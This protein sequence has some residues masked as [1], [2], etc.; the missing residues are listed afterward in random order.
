MASKNEIIRS[1][2]TVWNTYKHFFERIKVNEEK[3]Y[4]WFDRF[5]TYPEMRR[6]NNYVF[7][8]PDSLFATLQNVQRI[9]ILLTPQEWKLLPSMCKLHPQLI[10]LSVELKKLR[11][12]WSKKPRY[13][14]PKA[15]ATKRSHR[16]S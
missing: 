7:K 16:S 12:C 15:K 4:R 14:I 9:W 11:Q 2:N 6:V 13:A 1:V 3:F 8:G 5:R 10:Q